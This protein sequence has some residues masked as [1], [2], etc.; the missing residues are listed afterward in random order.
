[1]WLAWVSGGSHDLVGGGGGGGG[2]EPSAPV[3][4]SHDLEGSPVWWSRDLRA[5]QCGHM[6]SLSE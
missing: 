2:G 6:I 5:A 3:W 4:W 1:M